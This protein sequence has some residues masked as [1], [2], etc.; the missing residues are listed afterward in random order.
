[1]YFNEFG[2]F[3]SQVNAN[4]SIIRKDLL[5]GPGISNQWE[6][7]S[8]WGTGYLDA[9]NSSLAAIVVERYVR[10]S[11]TLGLPYL[12]IMNLVIR[13]FAFELT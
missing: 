7:D 3:I 6:P 4:E 9:Y 2:Q 10:P 8:V 1:V 12:T 11:V 13:V 5:L